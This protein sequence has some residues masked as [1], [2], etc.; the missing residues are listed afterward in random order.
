MKRK[1]LVIAS[2]YRMFRSFLDAT[3]SNPKDF[4]YIDEVEQLRGY[5]WRDPVLKIE[6]YD[7]AKF[8]ADSRP[9]LRMGNQS[10]WSFKSVKPNGKRVIL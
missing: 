8:P 4:V 10:D 7:K 2:S 3:R 6:G 1:T 5:D 9:M